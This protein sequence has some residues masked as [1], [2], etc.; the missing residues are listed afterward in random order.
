MDAVI[1]HLSETGYNAGRRLCLAQ[2]GKS[3]HAVYAPLA[4]PEYRASVCPKC[5]KIYADYA[6]EEGDDMPPYIKEI[7]EKPVPPDTSVA[8]ES[9]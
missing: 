9:T 4:N 5:L 7:R 3:H 2:D 1:V 6:Y 8:Q